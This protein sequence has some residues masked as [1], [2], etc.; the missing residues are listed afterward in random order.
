MTGKASFFWKTSDHLTT[1]PHSHPLVQRLTRL[2]TMVRRPPIFVMNGENF[3]QIGS[4]LP[5]PG[6]Q[7]KFAQL[8]IYDTDNETRNRVNS[9]W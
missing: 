6:N 9:V 8:Y 7:P 3:H 5:N 1:C 4:L 2:K